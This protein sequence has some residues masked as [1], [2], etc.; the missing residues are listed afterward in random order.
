M[1]RAH[2]INERY[3]IGPLGQPLTLSKLPPPGF[4]HWVPRRK[5]EVVVAVR[6]GLLTMDEALERY[7]L[8]IEEYASWERAMMRFGLGGLRT[9]KTS[10]YRDL[11]E[12]DQ[13]L[14]PFPPSLPPLPR[15]IEGY[16]D[17]VPLPPHRPHRSGQFSAPSSVGNRQS[18]AP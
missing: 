11:L 16:N 7:N 14:S 6:G 1:A 15:L 4:D 3:V 5:A 12:R 8:T 10:R 13:L 18:G 9:T 2:N 17:I